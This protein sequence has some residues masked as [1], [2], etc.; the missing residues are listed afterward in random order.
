MKR[1]NDLEKGDEIYKVVINLTSQ[2][3]ELQKLE[4]RSCSLE[5]E[6][7]L[8]TFSNSPDMVKVDGSES[9]KDT[10]SRDSFDLNKM[11]RSI[12]LVS[13]EELDNFL[14]EEVDRSMAY[15][16]CL[17]KIYCEAWDKPVKETM[18]KK[19]D[20]IY[21]PEFSSAGLYDGEGKVYFFDGEPLNILE[22]GNPRLATYEEKDDLIKT[23]EIRTSF[24]M[25]GLAKEKLISAAR[26][27]GWDYIRS[28]N[29]FYRVK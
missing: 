1:F 8:L 23:L 12:F 4:V 29:C 24:S 10:I 11:I 20:A 5:G 14:K 2:K 28:T 21:V 19:G 15:Q 25:I 26:K 7:R 22:I 13:L 17:E 3:P 6:S 27:C 9:R 16:Q 18:F